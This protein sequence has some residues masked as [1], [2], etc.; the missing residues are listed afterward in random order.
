[1]DTTARIQCENAG[2][3]IGVADSEIS[4]LHTI[5]RQIDDVELD[6]DRVRN[7]RDIVSEYRVMFESLERD[8]AA[9]SSSNNPGCRN[10]QQ[11][12]K[13]A[14]QQFFQKGRTSTEEQ[15]LS[16]MRPTLEYIPQTCLIDKNPAFGQS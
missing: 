13:K 9:S 15:T 3:A 5:L 16:L 7:I 14:F 4:K 6:L 8:L 2:N 12:S 1:M 10:A 11:Q